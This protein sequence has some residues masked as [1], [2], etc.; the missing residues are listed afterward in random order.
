MWRDTEVSSAPACVHPRTILAPAHTILGTRCRVLS[1]AP[2]AEFGMRR[3]THW[4]A[5]RGDRRETIRRRL[6]GVAQF[7]TWA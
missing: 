6:A 1:N 4:L 3:V 2:H 7:A 5:Q